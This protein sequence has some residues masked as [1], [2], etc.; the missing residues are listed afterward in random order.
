MAEQVMDAMRAVH[1]GMGPGLL[2]S[3]YQACLAHDLRSRLG[4][5]GDFAVNC[6]LRTGW[7]EVK[8]TTD[9]VETGGRI[10]RRGYH[11]RVEECSPQRA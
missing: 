3:T 5:L 10:G 2:E 7:I 8:F 11:K 1:R 9:D 4:G 6:S